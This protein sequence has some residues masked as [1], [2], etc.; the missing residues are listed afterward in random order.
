MM[1]LIL[2]GVVLLIIVLV[3]T[4]NDSTV[5]KLKQDAIKFEQE[6]LKYKKV[7]LK[8]KKYKKDALKYKKFLE[9]VETKYDLY[10]FDGG[11]SCMTK[12]DLELDLSEEIGDTVKYN[13]LFEQRC[14]EAEKIAAKSNNLDLENYRKYQN[15]SNQL[16][17]AGLIQD[18]Y[19]KRVEEFYVTLPKLPVE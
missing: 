9:L 6:A 2:V 16:L 17:A 11:T 3:A 10:L 18:E 1:E 12:D 19:H 14:A 4:K 7:A 15:Y 8:Y 13:R 5:K